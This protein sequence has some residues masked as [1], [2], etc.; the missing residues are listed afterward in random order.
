MPLD[1]AELGDQ[2][3][4]SLYS[5]LLHQLAVFA[6]NS[7]E[8]AYSLRLI[9]SAKAKMAARAARQHYSGRRV[10]VASGT[11]VASVS[12]LVDKAAITAIVIKN[13]SPATGVPFLY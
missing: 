6:L 8:R 12:G 5:K 1:R 4:R 10:P 3:G 7:S 13:F 2:P 9:W 11:L